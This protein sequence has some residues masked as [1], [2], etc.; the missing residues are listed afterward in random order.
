ML[1]R[2]LPL[3]I[4]IVVFLAG[5]AYCFTQFPGF[6]STRVFFDLLTDNAFLGIVAVGMTFVIL[7]GGIDLSVGSVIAFTGVLLAKLIGAYGIAPGYAFVIVL[8]M[9]TTFGALM[10][11]IIDTLKLPAFIIT[12]A[13]MFFVR[14]MSFIVSEES[15]PINHP[16]YEFL[17]NYAWK[18]PGGG[19]FT[20]LALVMLLVV[21]GG[22]ILA[23]RTRFGN[24]VYAV[25]GSNVSAALMGVPV[26]RTTIYIYMLSSTLAVLSGIIFSLYTSAGYALAASGVELDAIASVVIGGTLL[27]GGVGTVLGSLFGVL[28]QGLIQ[29]YITFDGTL[30][31]WW[32]KIVMGVLLFIFIGLQKGMGSFWTARRARHPRPEP[33]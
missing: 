10:G 16:V 24:N 18:M 7:S 8:L 28:I 3:L 1:K 4:T 19:R 21:L 9:G 29:T 6:A 30:S 26:R 33:S 31:S 15:L 11:W 32:T 14:G 13:G 17:A 23:H 27:S 12:L 22:I 20:L 2:N 5:Y 25:G